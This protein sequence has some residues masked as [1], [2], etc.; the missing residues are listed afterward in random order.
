MCVFVYSEPSYQN[1]PIDGFK[2]IQMNDIDGAIHFLDINNDG[3]KI[4][5]RPHEKVINFWTN[6][7]KRAFQFAANKQSA[8]KRDEL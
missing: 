8:E 1:D 2:P 5:L 3:L 7:E 4:G 6:I